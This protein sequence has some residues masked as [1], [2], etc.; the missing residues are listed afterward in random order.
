M[1]RVYELARLG[2]TFE[3]LLTIQR[4]WLRRLEQQTIDLLERFR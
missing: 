1:G 4:G 2:L 3:D